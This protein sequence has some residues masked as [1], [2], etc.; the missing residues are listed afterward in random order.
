M[1]SPGDECGRCGGAFKTLGEDITEELEYVPGRFIVNRIIRPRKACSCCE[2]FVQS[3]LPSRPI[4]RGKPS[5]QRAAMRQSK[6]KPIFDQLE[7]WLQAQLSK[8]SG[9]SPLAQAIR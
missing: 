7:A 1:L 3:P 8:I 5:E 2:A 9:K 4:E 6:A